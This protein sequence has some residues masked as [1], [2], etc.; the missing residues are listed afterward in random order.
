MAAC[1]ALAGLSS[2]TSSRQLVGKEGGIK[3]LI[4]LLQN[5]SP[6]VR[7]AA[8]HALSFELTDTPANVK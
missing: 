2:L 4:Q 1:G 6:T 8:A 3:G 5:A 7:S